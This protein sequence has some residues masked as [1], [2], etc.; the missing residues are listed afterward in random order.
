MKVF[1]LQD[2]KNIGKKDT[3]IDV[4]N[5]YALNYLFPNKLAV[6]FDKKIKKRILDLELMTQKQL[7]KKKS[8]ALD[9]QKKMSNI[10]INFKKKAS[11]NGKIIGSISYKEIEN[12]LKDKFNILINKRK[13]LADYQITDFGIHLLKIELFKNVIG[14]IKINIEKLL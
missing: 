11:P 13:I 9:Y 8:I 10:T 3:I 12:I 5:G 6:I 2:I 14:I 1:L 4:N 7:N